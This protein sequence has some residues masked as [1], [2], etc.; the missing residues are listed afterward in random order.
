MA[1]RIC[2]LVQNIVQVK[3]GTLLKVMPGQRIVRI[4]AT[5]F[6]PAAIVPTPLTN[7]SKRPKIDARAAAKRRARQAGHKQT[8]QWPAAHRE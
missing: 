2:T 7:K 4:V 8:S 3:N 1:S 5:K 6:T